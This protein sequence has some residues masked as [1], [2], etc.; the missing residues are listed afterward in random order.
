MKIPPHRRILIVDD[1]PQVLTFLDDLF[2]TEG[3]TVQ[4]AD[5]GS[6]GIDKLEQ[7]RFDIILTDLKMPGPDGI[8]V[9][10]TAKNSSRTPRSS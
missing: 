4:T 6:S 2:R 9:L 3:W 10:R 5:S 1:E 8:E 7:S